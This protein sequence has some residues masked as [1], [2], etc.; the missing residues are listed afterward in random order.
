MLRN[1]FY[2][3]AFVCMACGAWAEDPEPQVPLELT[4]EEKK[5]LEDSEKNGELD[6]KKEEAK[7]VERQRSSRYTPYTSTRQ[8]GRETPSGYKS[9]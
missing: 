6:K 4:A 2:L 7:P 8:P 5:L 9:F 1:K 3:L